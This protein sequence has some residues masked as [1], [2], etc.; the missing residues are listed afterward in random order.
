[1]EGK[2]ET[3]EL[4][5]AYVCGDVTPDERAAVELLLKDDAAAQA[6]SRELRA[7]SETLK[8]G[9]KPVSAE[10]LSALKRKVHEKTVARQGEL[11]VE[12]LLSAS[13]TNDLT[14]RER[15]VLDAHLNKNPHARKE[16]ESLRYASTQLN[17][18]GKKPSDDFSKKLAERLNAKLPATARVGTAAKQPASLS[19]KSAPISG[20]RPSLRV[21]AK[22]E[23]PWRRYAI[24]GAAIAALIAL[25]VGYS[26]FGTTKPGSSIAKNGETPTKDPAVAI[27]HNDKIE[28]KLPPK[29]VSQEPP[30][31]P[32]DVTHVDPVNAPLPKKIQP[33]LAP[34]PVQRDVAVP[35]SQPNVAPDAPNV[36]Q[37]L[38]KN[39]VN[40]DV[41]QVPQIPPAPPRQNGIEVVQVPAPSTTTGDGPKVAVADPKTSTPQ[42]TAPKTQADLPP[43]VETANNVQRTGTGGTGVGLTPNTQ[44]KAPSNDK[45]TPVVPATNMAVIAVLNG[46]G[47]VQIKSGDAAA[48]AAEKG[49]GLARGSQ[50]TTDQ[51]RVELLLPSGAKLWINAGSHAEIGTVTREQIQLTLRAGQIAFNAQGT[52]SVVSVLTDNSG[53]S[54]LRA[55]E[56]DVR[57][58]GASL[59]A[60]VINKKATIVKNGKNEPVN[61]NTKVVVPFAAAEP[62]Q[63]SALEYVD[64]HIDMEK[65]ITSDNNAQ[66]KNR[67][68][69]TNKK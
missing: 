43:G 32:A 61:A 10:L 55:S 39:V 19:A 57:I 30:R 50:I 37:T 14:A 59:V 20:E 58:E 54:V 4:L 35:K 56:V 52:P 8:L 48:H 12:A 1:V 26:Q 34:A 66:G 22:P 69:Q 49:E 67:S 68:G 3:L 21:Y 41:Q 27:Q 18:G 6:L 7:L 36:P 5:S 28:N 29:D 62:V 40:N 45:T 17:Q 24:A 46:R 51:S 44:I 13:L 63:K 38:P 42:N 11:A 15:E 47:N 60:S 64:W 16:L 53:I 23:T 2:I 33:E 65:T 9:R 25:G 31:A